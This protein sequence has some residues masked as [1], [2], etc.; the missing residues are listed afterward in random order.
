MLQQV[1]D[2]CVRMTAEVKRRRDRV[3]HAPSANTEAARIGTAIRYLRHQ[4]IRAQA[5]AQAAVDAADK[6]RAPDP[7]PAQAA[8]GAANAPRT[9]SPAALMDLT[10]TTPEKA[11]RPG[12]VKPGAAKPEARAAAAV[13][14]EHRAAP[15]APVGGL[16]CVDLTSDVS[17]AASS[18][19]THCINDCISDTIT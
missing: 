9:D 12:A 15:A 18:F 17:G 4:L 16:A 13:K 7:P 19:H 5:A 10:A 1:T 11:A 3:P 2:C 14:P 8:A 6:P